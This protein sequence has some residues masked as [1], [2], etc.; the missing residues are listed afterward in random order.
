MGRWVDLKI[1]HIV[2]NQELSRSVRKLPPVTPS[3]T[4]AGGVACVQEEN[5]VYSGD[6]ELSRSVRKLGG[7]LRT[8]ALK[9][10]YIVGDQELSRSVRKLPPVTPSRTQA[11]G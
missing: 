10:L 7:S 1:L 2:G 6:Q 3:R 9:I 11:R 4:Q 5:L 8:E